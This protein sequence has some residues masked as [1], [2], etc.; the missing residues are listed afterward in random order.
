M[1]IYVNPKNRASINKLVLTRSFYLQNNGHKILH[2]EKN[3]FTAFP[4]FNRIRS[5]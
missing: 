2:N 5:Y 1:A 3:C 4:F